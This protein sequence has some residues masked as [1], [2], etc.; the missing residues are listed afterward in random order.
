[1]TNKRTS[2][3]TEWLYLLFWTLLPFISVSSLVDNTL[4]PRQI[5]IGVFV[6]LGL[7][8]AWKAVFSSKIKLS[9]AFVS[10][11]GFFILSAISA[12]SAIN[13]AESLGVLARYAVVLGFLFLTIELIKSKKLSLEIFTKGVLIF[14]SIASLYAAFQLLKAA[15]DGSFLD[16]IYSVKGAFSHKNL[17]S[18]VLML[19]LP[20]AVIGFVK[21][22]S[23]QKKGSLVLVFL[24]IAEI[25]VL[26]TR[27]VWLSTFVAA[28]AASSVF[29]VIRNKSIEG[30]KFP[31]KLFFAGLGLALLVFAALF[32]TKEVQSS[33]ADQTNLETRIKFWK[34]SLEMLGDNPVLGVGP[35]NWKIHFPKY[36]LEGLDNNVMQG[37]THIQRPHNDY[38]WVL[39]EGGILSLVLYL[40]IFIFT[41]LRIRRNIKE[42]KT[43][44]DIAVD[45][46]LIFGIVAYMTFSLTDFPMERISINALLIGL[47]ALAH[48]HELDGKFSVKGAFLAGLVAILCLGSLGVLSQRFKGEK[49]SVDVLKFNRQQ[50]AQLLIPAVDAA[51]N[52]YF[53]LDNY[54]NPLRYFSA[55]AKLVQ[56]NPKG[57]L[58]DSE[59]AESF[60]PNNI[61]VLNLKGNALKSLGRTDEALAYYIKATDI[62]P[63]FESALLNQAELYF[64][65][66]DY[67]KVL[68]CLAKVIPNIQ[69][70][71]FTGFL[72]PSLVQLIEQDA[73]YFKKLKL[74]L[75]NGNPQS[76]DDYFRLYTSYLKNRKK[77]ALEGNS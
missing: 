42:A 1:M 49:G 65:E 57:S 19:S 30:L 7:A 3:L 56:K 17:L 58:E 77:P 16:G 37:I 63:R 70:Q 72:I 27:G 69:N 10:Y 53:N 31:K 55:L 61:L 20:F 5:Y 67:E 54:S 74:Y 41:F 12:F 21:L 46:A 62:A 45:L 4:I 36:N 64:Q 11:L 15:S 76:P 9:L 47:I 24:I 6:L 34:N 29:F 43:V 2:S 14:A 66:K 38:L 75:K 8:S 25:F 32:S 28:L 23:W 22:K 52:D 13:S 50:N 68:H 39:S 35:G 60:H 18:S 73:P 71:K 40:G 33:V 59:M 48:R 26:R 44:E 51:Q